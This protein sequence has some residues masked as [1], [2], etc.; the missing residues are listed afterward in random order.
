MFMNLQ[1]RYELSRKTGKVVSQFCG[2]DLMRNLN[3][4]FTK[5]QD[6]AEKYPSVLGL[7]FGRIW[8]EVNV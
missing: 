3:S 4:P 8:V 2:Y 6:F 5:S 7:N 1:E